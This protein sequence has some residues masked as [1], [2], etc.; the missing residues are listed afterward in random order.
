MSTVLRFRPS[1]LPPDKLSRLWAAYV[2][3]L[4]RAETSGRIEDGI[5]AGIAWRAWLS[6]FERGQPATGV[7][8]G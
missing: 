2:D 7:S 6:A 5:R 4:S 3:A 8:H 1:A